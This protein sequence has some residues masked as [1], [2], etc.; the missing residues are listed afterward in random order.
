[1]IYL[2][3]I[4]SRWTC[5]RHVP[6]RCTLINVINKWC[7]LSVLFYLSVWIL[8]SL[9]QGLH[10]VALLGLTPRCRESGFRPR[11]SGSFHWLSP[12]TFQTTR[13]W[14]IETKNKDGQRRTQTQVY[15]SSTSYSS[16]KIS[17]TATWNWRSCSVKHTTL[18]GFLR[19]TIPYHQLKRTRM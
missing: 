11:K 10:V 1:M 17:R 18:W 13:L 4:Q 16:G 8:A 9:R 3:L 15:T 6:K 19:Y 14:S 5:T 2:C 12:R 7:T